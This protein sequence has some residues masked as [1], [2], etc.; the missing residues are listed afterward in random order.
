M[1]LKLVVTIICKAAV[2][3]QYILKA[4][5]KVIQIG[6]DNNGKILKNFENLRNYELLE[7][8]VLELITLRK[9]TRPPNKGRIPVGSGALKSLNHRIPSV[10][11]AG[12]K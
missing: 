4:D 12:C 7:A 1:N 5:G 9:E 2:I 11:I 6:I 3:I 10:S 8:A